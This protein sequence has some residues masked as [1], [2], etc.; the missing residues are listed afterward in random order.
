MQTVS[1]GMDDVVNAMSDM[2]EAVKGVDEVAVS[3]WHRQQIL[4]RM[5]WT[6]STRT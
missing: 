4:L 1:E 5:Q 3:L 2:A 6:L